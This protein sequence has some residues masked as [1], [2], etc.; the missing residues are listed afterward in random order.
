MQTDNPMRPMKVA[1]LIPYENNSR[2]HSDQQ[3][4]QL[5]NSIEQWGFTIPILIDERNMILAGHGRFLAAKQLGIEEVPCIMADGWTSEQKRAYVIADNKLAE[6]SSWDTGLYFSELKELSE[7]GFDLTL[8]G[9]DENMHFS[10]EPN[11]QPMTS[12]QDITATDINSAA[13]EVG[14]IKPSTQRATDVICPHCGGE[15]EFSGI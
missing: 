4:I 2:V 13:E 14:T 3:V 8:A 6:N 7:I 5:A 12:Y 10:Y 11:L 15:F 9:F 1:D